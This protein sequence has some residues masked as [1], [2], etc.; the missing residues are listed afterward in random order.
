M[1]IVFVRLGPTQRAEIDLKNQSWTIR[2]VLTRWIPS[3]L[4]QPLAT[5]LSWKIKYVWLHST[6]VNIAILT[7]SSN[8]RNCQHQ[9]LLLKFLQNSSSV[10][11]VWIT[12]TCN[13]KVVLQ[14]NQLLF[15]SY[16]DRVLAN[17]DASWWHYS[18]R[19]DV[20]CERMEASN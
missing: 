2:A 10:A 11:K 9:S 4:T 16:C 13:L 5:I 18:G 17:T 1:L 8:C 12:S 6:F 15:S 20:W 19:V 14:F 3:C 7:T